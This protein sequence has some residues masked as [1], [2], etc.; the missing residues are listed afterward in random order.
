MY[1]KTGPNY[2]PHRINARVC[3]ELQRHVVYTSTELYAMM[4]FFYLHLT[5]CT[6]QN[7]SILKYTVW[8]ILLTA[9]IECIEL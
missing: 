1:K 4:I 3:G 6:R 9:Y 7:K 2:P 8:S 5:D